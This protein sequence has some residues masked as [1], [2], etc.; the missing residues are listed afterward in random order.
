MYIYVFYIHICIYTYI[1]IYIYRWWG[2][3]S[4]WVSSYKYI[5][6]CIYIYTYIYI[7]HTYAYTYIYI[8]MHAFFLS[9]SLS[10]SRSRSRLMGEKVEL[11]H[12]H[13]SVSTSILIGEY[14]K[15]LTRVRALGILST[16][17]RRLIGSLI[18]IGHFPQKWPIFSGSFVENVLQLTG[19]YQS[20][21]PCSVYHRVL[22]GVA[23]RTGVH[24][25]QCVSSAALDK[26]ARTRV[27]V[28]TPISTLWYT[29]QGGEDSGQESTHSSAYHSPLALECTHSTAPHQPRSRS[30]QKPVER[31]EIETVSISI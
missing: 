17:W 21:P 23:T 29:L 28:A 2:G 22:I 31:I 5:C 6:V 20:S 27:R 3:R 26:R 7:I 19:S 16:G 15:V 14:N 24:A 10:L 25:L 8:N 12:T 30:R 11:T 13:V 18:F 4:Y 9:F 1:C